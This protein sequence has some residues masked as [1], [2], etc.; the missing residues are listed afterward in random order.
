MVGKLQVLCK[1]RGD[2]VY[3]DLMAK[4]H[5][6]MLLKVKGYQKFRTIPLI[7]RWR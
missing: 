7:N 5:F 6:N 3:I 2:A 4:I 1:H